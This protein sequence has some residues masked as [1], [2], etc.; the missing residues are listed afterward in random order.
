MLIELLTRKKP[1]SYFS[2]EGDGLVGHFASLFIE[3]NLSQ[4]LDPHVLEME[5]KVVEEVAKL[6]LACIKLTR[7]SSNDENCRVDTGRSSSIQEACLM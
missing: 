5:A 1:F 4:I 7:G 3:G 2:S 6:A